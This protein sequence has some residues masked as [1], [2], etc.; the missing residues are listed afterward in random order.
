[1]VLLYK[2]A[3]HFKSNVLFINL[4]PDLQIVPLHIK[5]HKSSTSFTKYSLVYKSQA[6][7]INFCYSTDFE[8]IIDCL[9]QNI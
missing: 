6:Y 8:Y 5:A 2:T 4:V 3:I 9:L 1:M 7:F